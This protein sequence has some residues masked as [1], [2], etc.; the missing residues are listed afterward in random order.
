MPIVSAADRP[1]A[2]EAAMTEFLFGEVLSIRGRH[3][4]GTGLITGQ[5]S[6]RPTLARQSEIPR[7]LEQR[8]VEWTGWGY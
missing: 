7:Q 2:A 3:L 5:E 6:S 4:P 1:H 8:F